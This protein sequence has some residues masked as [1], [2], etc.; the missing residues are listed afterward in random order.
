MDSTTAYTLTKKSILKKRDDMVKKNPDFCQ[1]LKVVGDEAKEEMGIEFDIIEIYAIMSLLENRLIDVEP[2]NA[3]TLMY[4]LHD[5][6]VSAGTG[7]SHDIEVNVKYYKDC[8]EK[9]VKVC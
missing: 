3:R 8:F 1:R 7:D 5:C 4:M 9:K 2:Y 6:A